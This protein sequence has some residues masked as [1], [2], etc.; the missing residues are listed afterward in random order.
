MLKKKSKIYEFI[1]S[2][3]DYISLIFHSI[4]VV[5]LNKLVR[6]EMKNFKST[7]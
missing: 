5:K 7:M 1:I 4:S 3:L 2:Y 6:F